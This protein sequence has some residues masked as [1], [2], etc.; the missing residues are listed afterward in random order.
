MGGCIVHT[1]IKLLLLIHPL[2]V[3][4][5]SL[6]FYKI[7]LWGLWSWNL[8]HTWIVGGCI[9]YTEIRLSLLIRSFLHFIFLCF[10]FSNI[11]WFRQELWGLQIWKLVQVWTVV[12]GIGVYW[13]RTA[14]LYLSLYFFTF[15]SLQ[16]SFTVFMTFFSH[17]PYKVETWHTH[18]HWVDVSASGCCFL[19]LP[20]FLHFCFSPISNWNKCKL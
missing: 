4:F 20:L 5:L 13:N 15:V 12:G 17:V 1:G 19:S 2:F 3:Y 11:E 18:G 10:L 14:I 8:V 16:F 6:T 9:V 7:N